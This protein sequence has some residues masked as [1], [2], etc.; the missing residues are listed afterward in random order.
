[1]DIMWIIVGAYFL[2]QCYTLM[3]WRGGWRIASVVPLFGMVPVLVV[4]IQGYRQESNLW[5][6]LLVF[7]GPPALLYLVVLMVLRVSRKKSRE[8]MLPNKPR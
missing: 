4:T 2:A 6:I 7:A 8:Q 5:P 1:M 3:A